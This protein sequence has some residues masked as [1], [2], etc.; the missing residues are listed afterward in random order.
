MKRSPMWNAL[1]DA[2]QVDYFPP[3]PCKDTTLI[4]V[5]VVC[6]SV[7]VEQLKDR[8]IAWHKENA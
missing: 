4:C 2:R 7:V 3:T 5:C 6:G 1:S 8:H